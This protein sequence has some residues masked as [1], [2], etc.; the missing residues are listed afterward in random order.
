[1]ASFTDEI[2]QFNGYVQQQPVEA[3]V[4]VG[5]QR[6]QQFQEGIQK[7]QSYYD[8]LLALPIAKQETQDYVK[9]KVGELNNSVKN[10]VSGDFSD[11]R[12]INQ[13]GGLAKGIASDPIIQNGVRSTAAVQAG[14]AA[15][16][17]SKKDKNYAPQND[18]YFQTLV[19]QWQHDG[20]LQSTFS[21]QFTPHTDYMDRFQKALDKAHPG[22]GLNA[23]DV[24]VTDEQGN[25]VRDV[26]GKLQ[27]NPTLRSG[28]DANRIASLWQS[29]AS[30]P[31]VQQQLN[32]DG[33][34]RY[35]GVSAS[36]L[37]QS[38][39]ASTNNFISGAEKAIQDL[40]NKI[41]TDKTINV[42][43]ATRSINAYKE[44]IQAQKNR[45][46][47]MSELIQ[48][49]PAAA[50]A[51][52]VEGETLSSLVG[53]YSYQEM[54]KSPLWETNMESIK[55]EL[56]VTKF[57]LEEEKFKQYKIDKVADRAADLQ[58][59]LISASA[60]GKKKDAN[61]ND[62][63]DEFGGV[64]TTLQNVPES[65]GSGIGQ[66]SWNDLRNSKKEQL[67]QGMYGVVFGIY[68]SGD[69]I[70]DGKSPIIK[71]QATG[72]FKFNVG[73]NG[74][75][76]LEEA[77]QKYRDIYSAG[78]EAVVAGRA[79]PNVNGYYADI[80]PILR[81][82]KS[83]DAANT[84][85]EKEQ[86][87]VYSRIGGA[88]G[89]TNPDFVD[90]YSVYNKRGDFRGAEARL[91]QKYGTDWQ[92]G[93]KLIRGDIA[94]GG[95]FTSGD[96]QKSYNTFKSTFDKA[97]IPE[98]QSLEN[99]YKE[100]QRQYYPIGST[101]DASKNEQKESLRQKF[102]GIANGITSGEGD[103]TKALGDFRATLND[104]KNEATKN[105]IIYGAVYDRTTPKSPYY[106]TVQ[107]DAT[108]AP[109]KIPVD[110][111]VFNS[112]P[113]LRDKNQ[114]DQL[115]GPLLS[116]TGNSTTD[117][118]NDGSSPFQLKRD[119]SSPYQT[120]YHVFQNPNGTW[121]MKMYIKDSKGNDI[122]KGKPVGFTASQAG[123][124][125][126]IDQ[127]RNDTFIEAM[128]PPETLLQLKQANAGQ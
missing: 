101:F 20:D 65:S 56:D 35:R 59:A 3:M 7:V 64:S 70:G 87:A 85:L 33:W 28:I 120:S 69:H 103:I 81:E 46:D 88:I 36:T 29:V 66:S 41:A 108:S 111:G 13:I 67:N 25:F 24:Y 76:T 118:N 54:K 122:V 79:L 50:K 90:A 89:S 9:M 30:Q 109:I 106:L 43:D 99:K 102:V 78:R 6:E 8:N 117:V 15:I 110:A 105:N 10:G 126:A 44:Q 112:F 1:M 12:L 68:K 38:Q 113:E 128:I 123:I 39:K 104:G 74:Y 71:D 97:L 60:R 115:F 23:R 22:E 127:L 17:Q 4:A 26:A 125:K 84:E 92:R 52:L 75:A 14:F 21:E 5:V 86:A 32:I 77:H 83:L 114:F 2:P 27:V 11:Q 63:D 51:S 55:Y 82:V 45:F 42:A 100:K 40:Q 16:E 61:G 80:D 96:N 124:I 119:A 49:N 98:F 47:G 37:W 91:K 48:K 19:N 18:Q 31:D 93:L 72:Q 62:I 107:K 58:K 95:G 94:W 57:Q 121:D 73:V 34:S 116:I 53:A